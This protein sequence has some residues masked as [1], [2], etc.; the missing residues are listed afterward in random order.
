MIRINRFK[1]L[2][3]MLALS[4]LFSFQ[5]QNTN[6][7]VLNEDQVL[8]IR[9]AVKGPYN[10]TP[11]VLLLNLGMVNV[12]AAHTSRS[13]DLWDCATL[14]G[15]ATTNSF[16]NHVGML[17]LNPANSWK[18]NASNPWCFDNPG[19]ADFTPILNGMSHGIV[20]FTIETGE[21]DINLTSVNLSMIQATSCNTGIPVTPAPAISYVDIVPKL[22]HPDPG[23]AGMM[24]AF[25]VTGAI[26]GHKIYFVY[27]TTCGMKFIPG[28]SNFVDIDAPILFGTAIANG[29]GVATHNQFVPAGAA[30]HTFLFQAVDLIDCIATNLVRHTF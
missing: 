28:C 21:M 15:T 10:V 18:S 26:P 8:R 3:V 30:G 1:W 9:F 5:E 24:N 17:S 27:G 11:D 23:T 13:A 19:L 6:G 7:D 20:D 2:V 4:S 12:L 16:A 29:S 22:L 14:L 25:T